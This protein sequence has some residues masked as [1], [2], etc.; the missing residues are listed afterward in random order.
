MSRPKLSR[1]EL[2]IMETL[3]TRGEVSIREIQWRLFRKRAGLPIRQNP[4]DSVSAGG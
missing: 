1:L 4:D 3:W 2:K